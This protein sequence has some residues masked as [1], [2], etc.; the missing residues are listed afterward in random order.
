MESN[1]NDSRILYRDR[2]A[3]NVRR[4]RERQNTTQRQ[5]ADDIG[6]P[7]SQVWVIEHARHN[8]TFDMLIKVA[9]GLGVELSDLFG[10]IT[11]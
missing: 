4:I 7:V 1:F 8:V 9:V 5:L 11:E 2:L 10:P 3:H 6:S